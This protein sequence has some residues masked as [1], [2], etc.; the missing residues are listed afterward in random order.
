MTESVLGAHSRVSTLHPY[1]R[2]PPSL[3]PSPRP[4]HPTSTN[5]PCE[6]CISAVGGK[7]YTGFAQGGGS[8][9]ISSWPLAVTLLDD[10]GEQLYIHHKQALKERGGEREGELLL[11]SGRGTK[12]KKKKTLI[13]KTTKKMCQDLLVFYSMN[14]RFYL[15]RVP[16]MISITL[17]IPKITKDYFSLHGLREWW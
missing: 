8:L 15:T 16:H 14:Q 13:S 1:E 7:H 11:Y 12:P 4:S 3:S 5:P 2:A 9:K 6:L 17:T 10:R